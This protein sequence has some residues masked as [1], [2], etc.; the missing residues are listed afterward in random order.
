MDQ[1]QNDFDAVAVETI[2]AR[3][4]DRPGALMLILRRSDRFGYVPREA[5]R[6]LPMR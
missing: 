3:L 5:R 6:P 4:K 2:A 1:T